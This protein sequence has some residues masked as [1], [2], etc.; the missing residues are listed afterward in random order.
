M[1]LINLDFLST[2]I[3]GKTISL[4]LLNMDFQFTYWEIGAVV[5]L[6]FLLILSLAH[7]R[8]HFVDWSLK[9][10]IFGFVFGVIITIV[11][12]GVLILRGIKIDTKVLGDT[13][14]NLI[15]ASTNTRK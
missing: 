9:G 5:F 12:G 8:R 14:T 4:R 13:I 15:P 7:M 3:L 2:G 1:N 11:V 6:I 10:A